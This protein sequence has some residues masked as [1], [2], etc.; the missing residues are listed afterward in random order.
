MPQETRQALDDGT[1]GFERILPG[2]DRMY[3]DTDLPPIRLED[4]RLRDIRSSLA[5]PPW[6]RSA[7]LREM[8]VGADLAE[9]LSRHRAWR[10]FEHLAAGLQDTAVLDPAQLASLLLDRSC[11]RPASLAAA[12]PWW[13]ETLARLAAGDIIPE[14]IW[15]SEDDLAPRLDEGPG[16]DIFNEAMG[17]L[18]RGGPAPGPAREHFAMG[19][20]MPPLRGRIPGRL[21]RTW[22]KE[23]LA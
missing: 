21:V 20:V 23:V 13:E 12:G 6:Q 7:R 10:L 1:N 16:R 5:Q 19:H 4:D 15:H 3:P 8:G 2:A 17:R 18:P 9:R 14:A 11:P 22:V